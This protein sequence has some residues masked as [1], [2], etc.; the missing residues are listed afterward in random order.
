[1][2]EGQLSVAQS[3]RAIQELDM[4]EISVRR[5]GILL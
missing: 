2:P 3:R 1:M 4:Q 5:E